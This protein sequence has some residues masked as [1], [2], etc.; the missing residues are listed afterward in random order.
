MFKFYAGA[1]AGLAA[2]ISTSAFAGSQVNLIQDPNFNLTSG[3]A[4]CEINW[5]GNA[6]QIS[7]WV[8]ENSGNGQPGYNFV[9]LNGTSTSTGASGQDGTIS[10]WGQANGGGNGWNG[11]TPDGTN[12]VALDSDYQV[13][14]LQ[15]MI[16]GL[17]IGANYTLTFLW[18]GAQQYGYSGQTTDQIAASL[19]NQTF[20]TQVI[21]VQSH[22]FSGWMQEQ[23]TFTATAA[24]EALS[25]LAS[26]QPQVPPFALMADMDLFM[27]PEPG[28]I[29]L[30]GAGLAGLMALAWRR[31]R[32]V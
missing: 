18:A 3:S 17:K 27:A 23:F 15:Q 8:N 29:A 5:S 14:A 31:R 9:F 21:T 19:G 2:L 28:T 20:Y 30:F 7:P 22:G 16:T 26:G 10:L 12:F 4:S 11:N 25:F 1:V 13:G 6:C 24:T 32:T